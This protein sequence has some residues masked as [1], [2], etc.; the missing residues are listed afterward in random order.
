[1]ESRKIV[2]MNLLAEQ[3]WRYTHGEQTCGHRLWSQTCGHSG[4]GE[5]GTNWQNIMGTHIV[6]YA[7]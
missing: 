3:Q 6:P 5:V 1:M 4:E 2:L 7:N